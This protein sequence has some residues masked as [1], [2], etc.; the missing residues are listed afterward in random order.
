MLRRLDTLE[1]ERSTV[2]VI[3]N[4]SLVSLVSG[5]D[6]VMSEPN[7]A[8]YVKFTCLKPTFI[9]V[10]LESFLSSL[11]SVRA[12]FGTCSFISVLF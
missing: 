2:A 3:H 6:V 12:L 4:D 9:W 10:D 8:C 1:D 11:T 5:V 7:V